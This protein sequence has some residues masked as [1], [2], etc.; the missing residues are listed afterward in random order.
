M[1]AEALRFPTSREYWMAKDAEQDVHGPLPCG[2]YRV[3]VWDFGH[4][5]D[6]SLGGES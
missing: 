3:E 2:C 4:N 5:P 1:T 6:C